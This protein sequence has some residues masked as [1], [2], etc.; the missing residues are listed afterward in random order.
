MAETWN[1][2]IERQG[3]LKVKVYLEGEIQINTQ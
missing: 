3:L 2:K 1:S